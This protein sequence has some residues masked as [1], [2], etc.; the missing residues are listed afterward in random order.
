MKQVFLLALFPLVFSTA[1]AQ[2][3]S[4]DYIKTDEEAVLTIQ[5]IQHGTLA[6]SWNDVM[7]YVDP[8]GGAEAFEGLAEPDVIVITH[9]H[10]DH[11]NIETLEEIGTVG[12][13]LIAPQS[14]ADE[15]PEDFSDRTTVLKNGDS[16]DFLDVVIKAVPMYNLPETADS[17]HPKGWGNGYVLTFGGKDV[18]ISG[19]TEDIPE[20][21]SLE[22]IDVAFVCMNLP[23][24]MDIH[25]A[26]SAVLYFEPGI[27]YPY[28]HRGQDIEKF[29]ELV[30]AKNSKIE[31]RLR[32]WYP[33]N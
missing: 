7:V 13:K 2:R 8:T 21:R 17:R 15:L 16:I 11:L 20:M 30:T 28:H 18:Y 31:V 14:V 10:G 32:D 27:V 25:Q 23:Y 3:S 22:N 1:Y 33:G 4:A 24:T 29:R 26:A 12:V 19:D 6:L 5:P 9:L